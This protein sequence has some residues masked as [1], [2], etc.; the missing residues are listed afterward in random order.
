MHEA[1]PHVM[2]CEI[3]EQELRQ[4][5]ILL[6]DRPCDYEYPRAML[7]VSLHLPNPAVLPEWVENYPSRLK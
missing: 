6:E 2:S 3:F 1:P 7:K 4:A 5:R